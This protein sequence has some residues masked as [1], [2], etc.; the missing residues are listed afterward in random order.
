MID[1][2]IIQTEASVPIV[3]M[4]GELDEKGVA[5]Q[6]YAEEN[7]IEEVL[8]GTEW[9]MS[10]VQNEIEKVLRDPKLP[11]AR[12]FIEREN[13]DFYVFREHKETEEP[14]ELRTTAKLVIVHGVNGG[15]G[16]TTVATS[17]A[18]FYRA[19]GLKTL[20]LDVSNTGDAAFHYGSA[21]NNEVLKE[22]GFGDLFETKG[23][24]IVIQKGLERNADIIV[25][26]VPSY[27]PYKEELLD[28]AHRI[29]TVVN[30]S[31]LDYMKLEAYT[32]GMDERHLLVVNRIDETKPLRY[33][34]VHLMR[35]LAG[36]KLVEIEESDGVASAFAERKPAYLR[37]P[38]DYAIAKLAAE[39]NLD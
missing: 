21:P 24:R 25:A 39:L 22:T 31:E 36:G 33:S 34:F 10:G 28:L 11:D 35:S 16:V 26:D 8:T 32:D 1:D 23:E 2:V 12:V 4:T 18:S 3:I 19:R 15:S 29:V 17:L 7:G 14:L 6:R 20:L 27:S 30:P 13:E 37:H 38:F 5:F 9:R